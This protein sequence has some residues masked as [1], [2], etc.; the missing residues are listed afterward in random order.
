MNFPANH[1]PV[2]V[3]SNASAHAHVMSEFLNALGYTKVETMDNGIDAM[4]ELAQTPRELVV[5]DLDVRYIDGWM[6]VKE[7]KTSEKIANMP[8]ILIGDGVAPVSKDELKR[9]GVLDFFKMPGTVATLQFLVHST[10]TLQRTSGT[11]ENKYTVAKSALLTED[12]AKAK[13]LYG[14]LRGLTAKDTR[15]SVGLAQAYVQDD[16]AADAERVMAGIE[17][18]DAGSFTL[19]LKIR[20]LLGQGKVGEAIAQADTLVAM[21]PGSPFYFSRVVKLGLELDAVEFAESMSQKAID[22]GFNLPEFAMTLAK[23]LY[24][25][26]DYAGALARVESAVTTF[27][28]TTDLLNLQGACCRK[29]GDYGRAIGS[30]EAAL[31][32]SPMDAKIYF[33]L[34]V[35]A[36]SM[37]AFKMAR[38]YLT[39]CLKI[40]PGFVR[41]E[42]LLVEVRKAEATTEGKAS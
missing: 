38:E 5:V 34:A 29:L 1:N 19:T 23:C 32:L 17:D 30:Y 25:R 33:N 42:E 11:V 15:S 2:L 8:L 36:R 13:Q 27:G 10:L 4:R 24:A 31:L 35:C 9:Y 7:L 40:Q 26:K 41:A 21:A 14:E 6:L 22:N 28:R 18:P 12:T 37:R 3:V 20:M 39:T 16:Q